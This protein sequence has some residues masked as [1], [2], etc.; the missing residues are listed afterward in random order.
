MQKLSNEETEKLH[1][2]LFSIS[3]AMNTLDEYS[4][5]F[6]EDVSPLSLELDTIFRDLCS[7]IFP[8]DFNGYSKADK[9]IFLSQFTVNSSFYITDYTPNRFLKIVENDVPFSYDV[10]LEEMSQF[11]KENYKHLSKQ[12]KPFGHTEV[13][14]V[15]L[16]DKYVSIA[17]RSLFYLA[18]SKKLSQPISIEVADAFSSL[19]SKMNQFSVLVSFDFFFDENH[20]EELEKTIPSFAPYEEIKL[21]VL[22]KV[23]N[24]A[25]NNKPYLIFR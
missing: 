16:V 12:S 9:L 25:L 24:K 1:I 3:K 4:V 17:N 21:F 14:L 10:F 18:N 2:A 23:L 11:L 15:L 22:D 5:R 19:L 20:Y 6:L 8:P 7:L 13:P